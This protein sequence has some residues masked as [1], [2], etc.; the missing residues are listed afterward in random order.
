MPRYQAAWTLV[1]AGMLALSGC[2]LVKTED[3]QKQAA[4]GAFNPDKMVAEIW[5]AKVVPF[6]QERAGTFQEV[7]ALAAENLDAAAEKYGHKEKQGNAPWT[8]AAR[9]DGVIVA[10]ET[11]SRAGY[12]D[13]DVDG[14]RKADVRVAIGPAIR[15]TAIRDSLKFINFNEFKNQIEWAQY[16][17][18]FN[19]HVNGLLLEKLPRENL[20]GKTIKALGAYP[21]PAKGQLPLFV[22]VTITVGG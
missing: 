19:T 18:S 1:F 9:I 4:A 15:G 21:L 5:D 8:F 17:K 10:E 7:S 12:V 20:T 6:L 2:K 11:K 3:E 13:V 16:G 22:P 14:D